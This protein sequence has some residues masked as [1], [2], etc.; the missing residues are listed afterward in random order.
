MR[1]TILLL[2]LLTPFQYSIAQNK[3]IP[4]TFRPPLDIPMV[5]S[6]NFGELRADHFHSGIDIKTQGVTGKKVFAIAD[7]YVSRIKIQTNGYGHSLYINYPGGYTSVYGHLSAYNDTLENYVKAYQYRNHA[8]EVDI[9]PSP[10]DLPVKKGNLVAWSGNTG[11]SGGPH[12]HFEIRNTASQHT[13]NALRYGFDISDKISPHLFSLFV[14]GMQGKGNDRISVSRKEYDLVGENGVYR[15]KNGDMVA[16]GDAAGLGLECYDYMNGTSNRCGVYSLELLVNGDRV[17]HFQTDEFSF[18]ESR[19]INAHMDYSLEMLTRRR[20]HDLYRKPGEQLSM[21]K[22]TV[23][24][25]II[26]IAPGDTADVTIIASDAYGNSSRLKFRIKSTETPVDTQQDSTITSQL[27][28]WYTANHYSNP[29]LTM[30]IPSGSLYVNTLFHYSMDNSRKDFYPYI[31]HIHT[32]EV[33]MQKYATLSVKTDPVPERLLNKTGIVLLPKKGGPSWQGG[34][35]KNGRITASV[36]EF[37]DFTLLA[38][39]IPP[40]IVPVNISLDKEMK[41]QSSIRFSIKDQLSGIASFDGYIDN[42]WVL[43]EYEPKNDLLFYVFDTE[44][45]KSGI[46]HELELYVRDYAGNSALYHT[47]FTW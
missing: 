47:T 12:L 6:G 44:R 4:N 3:F 33:P 9:Y 18:N 20:T 11:S 17:Y 43:F 29:Y 27:F 26:S 21:N 41:G 24:D 46:S 19:Y 10:G 42:E 35:V 8:F 13:L 37:G 32:P 1:C 40:A 36:R 45:L 5:L 2:F 16:A 30:N 31:H 15:L 38:D 22:L 14:Y 23:D 25:G 34:E 7:G 28:K 39:T